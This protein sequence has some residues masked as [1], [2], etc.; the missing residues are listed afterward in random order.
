M[1]SAAGFVDLAAVVLNFGPLKMLRELQLVVRAAAFDRLA[2]A[3]AAVRHEQATAAGCA[4][5]LTYGAEVGIC[6]C[7][8]TAQTAWSQPP[9]DAGTPPRI[10]AMTRTSRDLVEPATVPVETR[11]PV[12]A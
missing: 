4:A 9:A 6:F 7:E 2:A 10:R 11:P 8:R 3:I 12:G 1:T 5:V